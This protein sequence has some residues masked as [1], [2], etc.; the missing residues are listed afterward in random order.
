[1]TPDIQLQTAVRS[2]LISALAGRVEPDSI[3]SGAI[4]PDDFPAVVMGIPNIEIS[5][6]ASDGQIVAEADMMLHLW[7]D[8]SEAEAAQQ[9][10]AETLLTLMDPPEA[11][12][13]SFDE[14]D[15]PRVYWRQD[16]RAERSALHGAVS[17]NA[18]IR[19]R[20]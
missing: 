7:F 4:R 11:E 13:I 10:S 2:K 8:A 9:A 16:D 17:L 1:M 6:Y 3:R 19:W 20:Q 5:G 15:R 14:W 12:G 18:V